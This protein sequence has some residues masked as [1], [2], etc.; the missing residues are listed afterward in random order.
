[1]RE[2]EELALSLFDVGAI[3][4]I[5]NCEFKLHE[6]YPGAPRS[7]LY[8]NLRVPP[9][10][11]LNQR[12]L[13]QIGNALHQLSYQKQILYDCVVGIPK[14][15]DP[16]AEVFS[17]LTSVPQLFLKKE[18][19]EKGRRVL[20]LLRGD[21]QKGQRVL[22]IDDV[23]VMADSKFEGIKAVIVNDLIVTDILVLIDWEH[24]GRNALEKAGFHV[25]SLFKV[26]D[27]TTLYVKEQ[28]ISQEKQKDVMSYLEAI[29]YYFNKI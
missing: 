3:Q 28:R 21:Y 26:S 16:L 6:K 23:L 8:F 2:L 7:P 10:G 25:A 13:E 17:R 24:G 12:L 5:E 27:L 4:F 19:T 15:G 20:P 18:E 11:N 1:M 29:N 9:K 14:A 22:I